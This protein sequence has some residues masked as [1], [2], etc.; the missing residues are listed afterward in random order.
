[1]D[2]V[3]LH[4]HSN[5]S[6]GTDSP[7][8][9]VENIKKSGIT[10]FSLTDHDTFEG[11]FEIVKYLPDNIKFI[12]G[13]EMTSKLKDLKCHIL[14][15]KFNPE[16]TRLNNLITRGKKLRREKL[17]KR[18]KYLKEVHNIELTNEELDW[19]YSRKSV[20][21]VHLANV[22][23]NRKLAQDN[24]PAMKKYLDGCKTGNTRFDG[25]EVIETIKN[26]G[27]IA[28]WAHPL[29]GEGEE[30]LNPEEFFPK[31]DLMVKS[32]IQGLECYYSRYSKKETEFLVDCAKNNN[33]IITAGSDYHGCNKNN[34]KLEG[35]D[36][37]YITI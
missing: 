12:W 9:L 33:L 29:G 20:V 6:D 36:K 32:G 28:V 27:G 21:K 13:V 8:E 24:I 35:Y 34:I 15:Y 2:R 26:A 16:D 1:M 22:L 17:E 10:T 25:D 31:L 19:L 18:I 3:D 11:C 14:G 5:F 30:H 7:E 23:V 37:K 4:I